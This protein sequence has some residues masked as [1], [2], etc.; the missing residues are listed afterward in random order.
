[1]NRERG[2]TWLFSVKWWRELVVDVLL[3][4]MSLSFRANRCR[5]RVV[6]ARAEIGAMDN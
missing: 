1:M 6:I 2:A 3:K 5:R 4:K